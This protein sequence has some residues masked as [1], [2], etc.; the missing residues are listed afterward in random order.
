MDDLSQKARGLA[1]ALEPFAGQVYFSPECHANYAALGFSPSMGDAAGV[2]LPDGPA[3]F[4]SRGSV[5][6]Q[7]PGE[8][9]ACAFGVFN[10]A[11][12]VPALDHGWSLTDAATIVHVDTLAP[13]SRRPRLATAIGTR[14][15][16]RDSPA[17]T[18][19]G[20]S[21]PTA[22]RSRRSG[23]AAPTTRASRRASSA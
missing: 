3:Y 8:V 11:A 9:V 15:A 22:R 20:R 18:A 21:A 2:A 10:P 14:T 13:W 1:A 17:P 12:V 4:T 6:G 16:R 7:V 5:M 19:A 23:S